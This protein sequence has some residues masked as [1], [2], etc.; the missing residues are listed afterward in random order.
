MPPEPPIRRRAP[1]DGRAGRSDERVAWYTASQ[2]SRLIPRDWIDALEQPD[3]TAPFLDP[4]YVETFRYLPNPTAGRTSPDPNCPFD[5][6]LPL[7]FTVDCQSDVGL[8][9]TKLRWKVAQTDNEPWV[10]MNCS[11]CH[12]AEMSYQGK[13]I[14]ADGGPTVADFQ[15]LTGNLEKRSTRRLP[16]RRSSTGS[17]TRFSA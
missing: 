3:S 12:T 11:A 4:A 7:G 5:T 16:T 8:G 15:G 17:P 14:R 6:A 9:H 10:G 1:T 13:R 2:G